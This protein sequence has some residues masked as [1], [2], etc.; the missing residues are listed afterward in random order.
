MLNLRNPISVRNSLNILVTTFRR[1]FCECE[2]SH[3]EI[4]GSDK[5]KC[6]EQNATCVETKIL[7]TG[8][9]DSE[10]CYWFNS[11]STREKATRHGYS[12]RMEA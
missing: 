8:S 11:G 9:C 10:L 4:L 1:H 12:L 7:V 2:G 6:I 3:R 5:P